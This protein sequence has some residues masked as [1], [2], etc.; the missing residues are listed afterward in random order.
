MPILQFYHVMAM[1]FCG[2]QIVMWPQDRMLKEFP[3]MEYQIL[4][5]SQ[6]V[7][8]TLGFRH[9]PNG[10]IRICNLRIQD[11]CN[12]RISLVRRSPILMDPL[13]PSAGSIR[14]IRIWLCPQ[15][16]NTLKGFY[17]GNFGNLSC[18]LS[19]FNHPKISGGMLTAPIN[20][21]HPFQQVMLWQA[22]Y[23]VWRV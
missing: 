20:R 19:W 2:Y 7:S 16:P 13:G 1:A 14:S 12:L 15:V 17:Q 23:S 8:G 6:G 10:S 9:R 18:K 4:C 21:G 5:I 22:D 11:I 3:F